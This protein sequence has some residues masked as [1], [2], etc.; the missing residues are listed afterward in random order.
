MEIPAP[1]A[2]TDGGAHGRRPELL[3]ADDDA[4]VRVQ[5]AAAARRAADGLSVLEAEDGAEAVRLGLQRCPGIALLGVRMPR[6]GGIEAAVTLRELRPQMRLALHAVDPHVHAPRARELRLPLFDTLDP[7][8]A[9]RWLELQV[10]TP[11]DAARPG[12]SARKLLACAVCGYGA[13][14]AVPPAR[15]PMCRGEGTWIHTAGRPFGRTGRPRR[16]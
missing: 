8:R 3:V 4:W 9:I 15:C 5:L 1:A 2:A 7:E 13:A 6:L 14:R 10:R 11:A 12:R 16:R